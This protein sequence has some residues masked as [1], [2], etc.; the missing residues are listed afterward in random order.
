MTGLIQLHDIAVIW[1][2]SLTFADEEAQIRYSRQLGLALADACQQDVY[3]D[4]FRKAVQ[5]VKN[6]D[7]HYCPII[8][9]IVIDSGLVCLDSQG[10]VQTYLSMEYFLQAMD[11]Y[12]LTA[13][14]VENWGKIFLVCYTLRRG[15]SEFLFSQH[16]TQA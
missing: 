3:P 4:W 6:G 1:L 11:E 15:E 10:Y 7:A 8:D 16:V 2:A 12:D 13:K 9:E 5:V 14:E